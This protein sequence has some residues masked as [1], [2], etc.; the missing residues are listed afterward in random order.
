MGYKNHLSLIL[1]FFCTI[2]FVACNADESPFCVKAVDKDF[3]SKIVS[4]SK[5]WQQAMLKVIR[6]TYK[7][8]E[9]SKP[10]ISDLMTELPAALSPAAKFNIVQTCKKSY[11]SVTVEMSGATKLLKKGAEP[12]TLNL[13]F[14]AASEDID[15]CLKALQDFDVPESVGLYQSIWLTSNLLRTCSAV[16]NSED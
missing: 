15:D 1:F 2:H 5:T 3:C 13:M 9:K 4:G 14:S 16:V 7:Q 8:A 11:D 6:T 10:V 12:R